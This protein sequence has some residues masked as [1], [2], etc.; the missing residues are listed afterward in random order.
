MDACLR[1]SD[2]EVFVTDRAVE[3]RRPPRLPGA[4]GSFGTPN[5]EACIGDDHLVFVPHADR[6][7][8]RARPI[9]RATPDRAIARSWQKSSP[10]RTAAGTQAKRA[11]PPAGF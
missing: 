10:D 7:N 4:I 9:C 6:A 2:P 11:P 8:R 1:H 3:M 5:V